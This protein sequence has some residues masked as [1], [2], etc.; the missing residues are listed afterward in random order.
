MQ[1]NIDRRGRTARIVVGACVEAA[2]MALL[3]WW[4]LGGPG[5]TIWPAAGCIAGGNF[6]I[7]E[8]A[9]GWCAERAMGFRTPI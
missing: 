2:G 9:L 3:A 8:G 4:F 7:I 1:C 6:A 5:W